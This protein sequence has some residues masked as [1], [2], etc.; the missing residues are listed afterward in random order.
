MIISHAGPD[1]RI[2]GPEAKF[3]DEALGPK[4]FK[5]FFFYLSVSSFF[6]FDS[7]QLHLSVSS[8][9][10]FELCYD[11]DYRWLFWVEFAEI[12]Q[13]INGGM[14]NGLWLS[15]WRRKK[16]GEKKEIKLT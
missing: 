12:L 8:F 10:F 13:S 5:S 11:G 7:K 3:F 4:I 16:K 6:F 15:W 2:W 9:F 14:K 1:L